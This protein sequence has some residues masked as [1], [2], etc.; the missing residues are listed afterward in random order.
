MSIVHLSWEETPGMPQK[1]LFLDSASENYP[2]RHVFV[3]CSLHY[4]VDQ[5]KTINLGL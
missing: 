4:H 2:T 1:Q 3:L 5:L